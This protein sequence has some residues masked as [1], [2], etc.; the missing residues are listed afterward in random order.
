VFH[1]HHA[2]LELDP[3]W[4]KTAGVQHFRLDLPS[5]L[6]YPDWIEV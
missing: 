6:A 4:K 3:M 2:K 1:N 5:D